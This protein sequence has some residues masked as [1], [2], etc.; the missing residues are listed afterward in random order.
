[1]GGRIYP[2]TCGAGEEERVRELARHVDSRLSELKR[3]AQSATDM[4]LLV[5]LALLLADELLDARSSRP[6]GNGAP[7]LP[8]DDPMLIE[9]VA[10]LADRVE[11]IAAW[12][13]Q[14]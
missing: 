13:E 7:S 11:A 3:Q 10:M 5:M 9:T 6:A 8:A 1:M 2:V 14:S 4:H 12:V